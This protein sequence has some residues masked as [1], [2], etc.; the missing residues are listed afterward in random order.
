MDEKQ[1]QKTALTFLKEKVPPIYDMLSD[2]FYVFPIDI[3]GGV[4]KL[5]KIIDIY[6]L[7]KNVVLT[8]MERDI[9]RMFL[10][11]GMTMEGKRKIV[12]QVNTTYASLS[13]YVYRL[14]QRGLLERVHEGNK[15]YTLPKKLLKL[16]DFILDKKGSILLTYTDIDNDATI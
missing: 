11:F 2:G 4:D 10:R 9:M 15:R 6:T 7:S 3:E 14:G 13:Q 8:P 12:K 1:K 5:G 16:R